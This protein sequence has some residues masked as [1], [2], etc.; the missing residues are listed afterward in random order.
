MKKVLILHQSRAYAGTDVFAINLIHGLKKAHYKV[1]LIINSDNLDINNFEGICRVH[2][3]KS[4]F[5]TTYGLTRKKKWLKKLLILSFYPLGV[6]M[7]V[8]SLYRQL[9]TVKPDKII[10][11]N[12]GIPGGELV[13]TG[14]IACGVYNVKT[15]YSIHS[16]V[17][18]NRIL[19]PYFFIVEYIVS[20]FSNIQFVSVSNYNIGKIKSKSF[21]I[22]NLK[23]I[24]NGIPRDHKIDRRPPQSHHDTFNLVYV[25]NLSVQK[26]VTVLID[27]FELLDKKLNSKLYL[28]GKIVDEE[29]YQYI[30]G[31][32]SGNPHIELIIDEHNKKTIFYKKDLLI[33]PSTKLESF[34]Q[35]LVEAMTYDIPILGSND[36]GIK[37][38]IEIDPKIRAGEVFELGNSVDLAHKI[39]RLI[40][41]P[42]R[43]IQYKKNC[44][45]LY[46]KYFTSSIMVQNYIELLEENE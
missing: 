1:E 26:G 21:F 36:L 24:Y 41:E 12:A 10:I 11:V 13:Y 9:Q 30:R 46:R 2:T 6:F 8:M 42:K 29:L 37:E 34:G 16:G 18:Y 25:G 20:M 28:Y 5:F 19:K 7:H 17:V 23:L 32:C 22:K 14:A 40:L 4:H 3:Y 15:I 45:F 44:D 38:V 35:V 27:A 33:L 39:S 31:I 43:Y